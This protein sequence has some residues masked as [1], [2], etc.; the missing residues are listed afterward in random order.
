MDIAATSMALSNTRNQYTAS[1]SML[2][3][4]MEMAEDT[5][6]TLLEGM[7]GAI[8]GLGENIDTYV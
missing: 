7:G 5:I 3:N 4:V 8:E 2:K 6:A 1:V